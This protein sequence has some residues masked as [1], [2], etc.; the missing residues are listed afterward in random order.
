MLQPYALLACL[1]ALVACGDASSTAPVSGVDGTAPDPSASVSTTDRSDAPVR[2]V[3][4][5]SATSPAMSADSLVAARA[6]LE[7]AR[8]RYR[9]IAD[10]GGWPTIPEGDL[11]E[12]GDSAAAQVEA[13]RQR[14]AATG[15]LGDAAQAGAVYDGPLVA[16]LARFQARHGLVV[17]SL[18][19]GNTR[20]A[21]NVPA[22]ERVAQIETTLDRW[23][24]LPDVPTGPDARYVMVNVPEY[25]VRAFEGGEEALQMEVVVGAGYDDR[26]TPLFHDTM[27]H[28]IFRPYWNVPPS[29]ATEELVPD[30]PAALQERDFEIISHYAVDATVYDMTAANLQRVANGSLRI[31]Q[32]PGPDNALGLVKYMFPNDY[33]VYL[34]DTPADQLFEEAD[35]AF[36]HGCIRLERPAEF[37]AWVLGPQGWDEARVRENMTTGDRQRVELEETIPV[38]IVYLPV[39]A[40]ADGEVHFSQDVYDLLG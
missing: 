23:D 1:L 14:L 10:G 37:G 11:V 3:V 16:A 28:V 19:G 34:H 33:A 30:G 39:W 20:E 15:S 25:T 35:R 32:G 24:D 21:L 31:R 8:A 5:S 26:A 40:D 2:P 4:D 22:S 12:P 18:L 7:E 27:E 38:Y 36:S 9:R 17:D 13:L 29:I 6:R